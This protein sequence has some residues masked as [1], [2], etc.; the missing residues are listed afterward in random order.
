MAGRYVSTSRAANLAAICAG[1]GARTHKPLSRQDF[2]CA[3]AVAACS[4]GD[5]NLARNAGLR[6]GFRTAVATQ[7]RR[8]HSDL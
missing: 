5:D 3:P 4:I 7:A 8:K 1:S 2:K 6:R